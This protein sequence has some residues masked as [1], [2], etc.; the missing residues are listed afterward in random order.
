[1]IQFDLWEFGQLISRLDRLTGNAELLAST[2]EGGS[3]DP[4]LYRHVL[5][6][7]EQARDY[8]RAHGFQECLTTALAIESRLRVYLKNAD[9]STLAT[10]AGQMLDAMLIAGMTR[11]FLQV[12]TER[13]GYVDNA[14][15]FGPDVDRAFPSA[16][17]DI[18]EAG[19][20][21]ATDLATACVFHLMRVAEIGLRVLAWDREAVLTGKGG[22][23][24]DIPLELASWDKILMELERAEEAIGDFPKTT[25]REG[26]FAFYHGAMV[27]VRA[28]KNLYRN[29]VM[30]TR[31]GYD[32]HQAQS[33]MI[34]VRAFMQRLATKL[35]EKTRT[36]K[37]WTEEQL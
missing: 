33:A 3:H 11:K 28:F 14:A 20:C 5:E 21:F 6:G 7:I 24:L 26:Q 4:E 30:H 13:A 10:S 15:L 9:I 16:R 1:L 22:V 18:R 37:I 31:E 2:G 17:D 36:P 25:A 8:A 34:H 27:E 19:N 12:P 29:R 32:I 23:P 35:S